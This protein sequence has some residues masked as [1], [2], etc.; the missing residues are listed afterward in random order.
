MLFLWDHMERKIPCNFILDCC[1]LRRRTEVEL[2]TTCRAPGRYCGRIQQSSSKEINRREEE[3]DCDM[4][5]P[6]YALS[7][8]P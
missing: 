5:M 6:N 1:S 2:E 7:S 4:P 8:S 3:K